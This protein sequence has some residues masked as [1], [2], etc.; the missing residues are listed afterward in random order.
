[1]IFHGTHGSSV[2]SPAGCAGPQRGG[3]PTH[4]FRLLLRGPCPSPPTPLLLWGPVWIDLGRAATLCFLLHEPENVAGTP[5][6]LQLAL[7]VWSQAGAQ[8]GS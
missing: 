4:P 6:T 7:G 1:M 8:D 2:D 5:C 3:T